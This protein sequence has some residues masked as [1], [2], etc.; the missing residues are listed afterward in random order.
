M[1][2]SARWASAD[3]NSRSSHDRAAQQNANAGLHVRRVRRARYARH[4]DRHSGS[5]RRPAQLVVH[6][7]VPQRR[8]EAHARADAREVSAMST[9]VMAACWP[10]QL[11]GVPKAVLISLADNANDRGEC[12]PSITTICHRVGFGRTA[13][14]DA[15]HWLETQKLLVAD[16][17]NGR[18]TRYQ[19][20]PNL[21]LFATQKRSAPH[22]GPSRVPV[23]ERH[24]S[25]TATGSPRAPDQSATRTQP[26]RQADTNR[27]EPS[28]TKVISSARATR[29]PDDWVPSEA[30]KA[31]AKANFPSVNLADAVAE[32]KDFWHAEPDRDG[33][34]LDWDK[35]FRNR[36][37]QLARFSAG[38]GPPPP[39][40]R[41]AEHAPSRKPRSEPTPAE[42]R[43]MRDLEQK[44]GR[45]PT[46]SPDER[47]A[48]NASLT[49]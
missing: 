17:S 4:D 25:A 2:C 14:M 15:I 10:L 27:Q 36:L 30:L 45:A 13:V 3:R 1:K 18:H 11:P 16:R 32:F 34:K 41:Y 9:T 19:V 49:K 23:R 33:C 24:Q 37:R 43:A 31:E 47:S 22:T 40:R 44:F 29:L 35:V 28:R 38:K 42:Q 5:R 6:G 21:D 20:T 46:D 8:A 26:V 7:A 12:W 48:A 39:P